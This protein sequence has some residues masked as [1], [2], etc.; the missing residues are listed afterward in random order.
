MLYYLFDFLDKQYDFPG[1]GVFQ[2]LSFRAALAAALS[3]L[4][5]M[6]FGKRIINFL[7]KNQIG[8]DIRDL[9]L[10]GQMQK[11]G[12]PTMGGI[13]I[14]A[15]ILVPTLLVAKLHNIYIIIILLA[16]VWLGTLGFIDDYIKVFRKNKAGLHGKFKILGQLGLGLIVG[17]VMY[18]NENIVIREKV[19]TTQH[20]TEADVLNQDCKKEAA[21]FFRTDEI[22]SLKTTIPFVK[23]NEFDYGLLTA[24]MGDAATKWGWLIFIPI[25]MFIIVAVSNG[26]NLTDGMDGLA[27]GTSAVVGIVLGLLAWISGNFIFADYLNVMYIPN[28]G[29]LTIYI[30]A[31]VGAMI[32]FLWYNSYPAQVFM[33]DTGSLTIGGIIAVFAIMIR[34][35]LLIPILCFVFVIESLSVIIQTTMFKYRK[36]RFGHE[37]ASSHRVFLMSPIHHHYHKKGLNE[38]KIVNR[39]IIVSIFAAILTIV[40]LKLR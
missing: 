8:E 5:S 11:K 2:Y 34:K 35:E 13:I 29:E 24:W 23:D 37:Y 16:T 19:D 14:L 39:F 1:A 25:I 31:F 3:L 22:K 17:F 36:K 20:L 10:E 26:A 7:R 18:F 21:D 33:G 4:I 32:G 15:A 28:S 40:T 27:A 6:V 9:G 30:S 12:T 38:V